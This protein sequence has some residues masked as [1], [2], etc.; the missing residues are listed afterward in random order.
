M[1]KDLKVCV[2]LA[3]ILVHFNYFKTAYIKANLSDFV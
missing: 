2:V 1:F 3:L